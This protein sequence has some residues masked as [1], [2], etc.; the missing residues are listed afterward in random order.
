MNIGWW[1]GGIHIEPESEKE[2]LALVT[3]S[4]ALGIDK[5]LASGRYMFHELSS[6]NSKTLPQGDNQKSIIITEELEEE[7]E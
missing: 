2:R 3:I 1:Q 7:I 6:F 5:S 4:E